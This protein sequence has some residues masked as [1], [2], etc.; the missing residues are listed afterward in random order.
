MRSFLGFVLVVSLFGAFSCYGG[1]SGRR[2]I[3]SQ[4]VGAEGGRI[5]AEGVALDIPAGALPEGAT[6]ISIAVSDDDA[7]IAGAPPISKVITLEP[8]GL[9]FATPVRL[10]IPTASGVGGGVVW[11]SSP[12]DDGTY[13]FAGFAQGGVAIA[14][15]THFSEVAVG[16]PACPTMDPEQACEGCGA[17]E[18]GEPACTRCE[19]ELAACAKPRRERCRRLCLCEAADERLSPRF[20]CATLP[21]NQSS[22][23]PANPAVPSTDGARYLGRRDEEPCEGWSWHGQLVTLC[24]CEAETPNGPTPEDLCPVAWVN[25]ATVPGTNQWNC[26]A[27]LD[28]GELTGGELVPPQAPVAGDTDRLADRALR[29][30]VREGAPGD[31]CKGHWKDTRQA[32]PKDGGTLEGKLASCLTVTTEVDYRWRHENGSATGCSEFEWPPGFERPP[33]DEV[34]ETQC[35][36]SDQEWTRLARSRGRCGVPPRATDAEERQIAAEDKA[37]EE[38]AKAANKPPPPR[39]PAHTLALLDVAGE[40]GE[41]TSFVGMNTAAREGRLGYEN[42]VC[43]GR[44]VEQPWTAI[45]LTYET[46]PTE[47][48][49][50]GGLVQG[51]A[52]LGHAEGD[53]LLMLAEQRERAPGPEGSTELAVGGTHVGGCGE[54]LVDRTACAYSC[55]PQ[56][57]MMARVAAGLE[58]LIVRSP[59]G[60]LVYTAATEPGGE[61]CATDG[62]RCPAPTP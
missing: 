1:R 51:N 34:S 61:P 44:P 6:R 28:W 47:E 19:D 25:D 9:T 40:P 3:A 38:A 26:H 14:S 31:V 27:T 37:A 39:R 12:D 49:P 33:R 56:G 53:A 50:E 57:I 10:A 32:V 24:S 30:Y 41:L 48:S 23:C 58:R 43:P 35:R 17:L 36:L 54:M 5:E 15:N 29:G 4:V 20:L 11:W 52:T 46:P 13:E 22:L 7:P 18:G 60:C 59:S 2:V 45:G 8:A 42:G 62:E 21:E 55:G 16:P